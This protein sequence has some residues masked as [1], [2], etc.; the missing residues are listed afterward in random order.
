MFSF[1]IARRY[2]LSKKS[3][4]A[5][6]IIS[7]VSVFGVAIATAAL[8]CI[9][10]VFNGFQDMVADLFTTFDPELKVLPAQGKYM[11]ADEK[12]LTELKKCDKIA[13]Y[14]ET[15]EDNALLMVN[16]RQ[17]MVTIKGVGDN[18][19]ELTSIDDI[20]SGEGVYELSADVIDYGICGIGLLAQ[21]GV[22]ADCNAPFTLYAPRK[23]EKLDI[24]NPLENLN[25]E[26]VFSPK[27]T[28]MVKQNKYDTNYVITSIALARRLFERQG[29]ATAVEIKLADG[30]SMSEGKAAV[31]SI[32][33]DKY[34]VLD[35]YEQQQDTFKV[36]KIEK[37]ISYV[38][39]TFILL[40]A[41][42][43]IVGSLTMLIIDKKADVLTLR[44]LGATDKQ[45]KDIFLLE[46][47]MISAIGAV[48]GIVI[49]VALCLIQQKYGLIRFGDGNNESYIIDSYP[50]SVHVTDV[51]IVLATVLAVG[52]LSVWY[53]CVRAVKGLEKE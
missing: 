42:F 31:E 38:F 33:G 5:I 51:I 8:V 47:R 11:A 37:F 14:M 22:T 9:L 21:L 15:V 52:F 3:H 17:K 13:V 1:Q 12:E 45:I 26:E 25:Q 36:M 20:L 41:C 6:N 50:V 40:I 19:Q 4:H 32:L 30:V 24:T 28:F 18:F 34:K 46:G 35:R 7:G 48:I 44:N 53:P 27:V 23:G 29:Y 43:N 39:L 10:S 16:N 2:L 49:G